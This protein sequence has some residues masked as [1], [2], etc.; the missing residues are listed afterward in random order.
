[1]NFNLNPFLLNCILK[2]YLWVLIINLLLLKD[3]EAYRFNHVVIF[4]IYFIKP[5]DI[6][7]YS[8]FI[9]SYW[10]YIEALYCPDLKYVGFLSLHYLFYSQYFYLAIDGPLFY[11]KVKTIFLYY[12]MK[13]IFWYLPKG[14]EEK[15]YLMFGLRIFHFYSKVKIDLKIFFEDLVVKID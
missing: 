13:I 12:I 2:K 5:L 6:F 8:H 10:H 7:Y 15:I 4:S 3:Y 14:C 1:M 9:C 11:Y